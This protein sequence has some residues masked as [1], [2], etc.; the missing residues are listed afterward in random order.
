MRELPQAIKKFL[1]WYF[2][3]KYSLVRLE[4]D[5]KDKGP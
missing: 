1:K 4:K 2:T 3:D 5:Q